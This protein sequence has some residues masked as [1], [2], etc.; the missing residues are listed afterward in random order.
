MRPTTQPW[1]R[2]GGEQQERKPSHWNPGRPD[3]NIGPPSSADLANTRT[4]PTR[5]QGLRQLGPA[6]RL[7]DTIRTMARG[8]NT[9]LFKDPEWTN[10]EF[11]GYSCRSTLQLCGQS[12]KQRH[13]MHRALPVL[14]SSFRATPQ[15]ITA[16]EITPHG[17]GRDRGAARTPQ[18]AAAAPRA[19]RMDLPPA[20]DHRP[21]PLGPVRAP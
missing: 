1:R 20:R 21:Y 9:T 4:T 6:P 10:A 3:H 17:L 14:T 12:T 16:P 13:N 8:G 18:P 5:T 11:L 7:G 15:Q 19:R 2:P